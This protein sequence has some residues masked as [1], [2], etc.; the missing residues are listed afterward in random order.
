[1]AEFGSA[2]RRLG[3]RNTFTGL[4]LSQSGIVFPLTRGT[5]A[6]CSMKGS[7]DVKMEGPRFSLGNLP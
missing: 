3:Q 2:V 5:R 1:M 6:S 7:I 4:A